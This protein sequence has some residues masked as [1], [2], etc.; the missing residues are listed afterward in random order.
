MQIDGINSKGQ[1]NLPH[2]TQQSV[3]TVATWFCSSQKLYVQPLNMHGNVD[4][5]VRKGYHI[6]II[7]TDVMKTFNRVPHHRVLQKMKNLGIIGSTLNWIRAFLSERIQC[8]HV[9]NVFSSWKVVKSGI[10]QGLVLELVLLVIF[11]NDMSDYTR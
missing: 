9:E 8:E 4:R 2:G 5:N 7:Y 3:L 11:I 1:D 10:L 6:D